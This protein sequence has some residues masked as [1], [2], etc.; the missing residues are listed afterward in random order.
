MP[1]P[2]LQWFAVA[3]DSTRQ[4]TAGNLGASDEFGPAALE[5]GTETAQ[6]NAFRFYAVQLF[7]IRRAQGRLDE[8]IDVLEAAAAAARDLPV[9]RTG[10]AVAYCDLDHPTRPV[11]SD[12]RRC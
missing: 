6:P 2:W 10:I 9:Y 8:L 3:I 12:A 7:E 11:T 4:L 1:E 5:L